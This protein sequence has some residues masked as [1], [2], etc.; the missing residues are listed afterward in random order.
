MFPIYNELLAL[1]TFVGALVQNRH[2]A[3]S[4]ELWCHTPFVRFRPARFLFLGLL[5]GLVVK[6]VGA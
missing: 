6:L 4:K 1:L 3:K 2:V 5:G